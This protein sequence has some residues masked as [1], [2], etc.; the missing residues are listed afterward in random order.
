MVALVLLLVFVVCVATVSAGAWYWWYHTPDGSDEGNVGQCFPAGP[1][2][3]LDTSHG[4][5]SCSHPNAIWQITKT[6]EGPHN[7]DVIGTCGPHGDLLI[8]I[9]EED[10][11]YCL[12]Y[13]P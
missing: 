5:V 10:Q 13:V 6:I 11:S 4:K 2:G 1:D 8:Y 9:A 7:E 12:D 3:P